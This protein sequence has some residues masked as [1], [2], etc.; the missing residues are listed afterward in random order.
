M[1]IGQPNSAGWQVALKDPVDRKEVVSGAIKQLGGEVLSYYWGLGNGRN[2]ITMKLPND[3][4]LIQ[5][6]YLSRLPTGILTSYQV[7]ELM[8]SD[9]AAEA[10]KKANKLISTDKTLK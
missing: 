8:P 2:Y 1:F 9:Q 4:E 6:I 5:A 3:N 7:I 10:M